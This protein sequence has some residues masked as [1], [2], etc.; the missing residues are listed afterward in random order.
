MH[1]A[2]TPQRAP[3]LVAGDRTLCIA[4]TPWRWRDSGPTVPVTFGKCLPEPAG[5]RTQLPTVCKANPPIARPS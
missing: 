3:A 4:T 1:R 5:N 2:A